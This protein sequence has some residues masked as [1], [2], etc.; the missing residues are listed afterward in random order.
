MILIEL[1]Y[2]GSMMSGI[3]RFFLTH[4]AIIGSGHP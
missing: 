3:A 4:V 2:W 1:G